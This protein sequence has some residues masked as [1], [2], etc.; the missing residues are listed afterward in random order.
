MKTKK[1]SSICNA[2]H[3]VIKLDENADTLNCHC[4]DCRKATGG[5][6]ISVIE[7]KLESLKLIKTN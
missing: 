7:F 3:F 2:V 4:I 5:S 1:G 6:F